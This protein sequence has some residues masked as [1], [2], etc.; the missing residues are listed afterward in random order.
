MSMR[1]GAAT[2][3]KALS[4][5]SRGRHLLQSN[6]EMQT[7]AVLG[8]PTSFPR[9]KASGFRSGQFGM[10]VVVLFLRIC[11]PLCPGCKCCSLYRISSESRRF[12]DW[13]SSLS[14]REEGKDPSDN[15]SSLS[16]FIFPS[17]SIS[18][19]PRISHNAGSFNLSIS[20]CSESANLVLFSSMNISVFSDK[21]F[22]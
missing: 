2:S 17:I 1:R 8:A 13:F 3:G 22:I 7:W 16:E 9:L 19:S 4:T 21:T 12:S 10:T 18:V 6:G 14:E 11:M 20:K 5:P 15:W